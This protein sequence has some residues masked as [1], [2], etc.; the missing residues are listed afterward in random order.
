MRALSPTPP[1]REL[2][3]EHALL[4][5]TWLGALALLVA[6]DHWLKGSGLL[7][8]VLT[9]KLSDFAGMLVAPVLLASLL[10]VGTRRGLLAC[11]VAVVVV[12][13]A[14]QLSPEF[15]R[16]WSGLM[17]L[18]GHPWVITCDPTDLIAVPFAWLSW[19]L[20][21]PEMA[22]ERPALVGL[23]RTAV[24]TVS[25]FGLWATVATSDDSGSY[26]ECWNCWDDT[27]TDG[28]ETEETWQDVFGHVY[29]HN[30]NSFDIGITIRTLAF[31]VAIDC[32][33]IAEDPARL[34]PDH[35]FG[36]AE[37]WLLPPTT[38]VAI[39]L[40]PTC[41]AAKVGGEGIQE[42]I[43]FLPPDIE[44]G[45]EM[46]PGSHEFIGALGHWGA[47]I[48]M[49]SDGSEWVGGE[50]WRYT[51]KTDSDPLPEQCTPDPNER[52][53]DW[54]PLPNSYTVQVLSMT[55]GLDGCFEFELS[56]WTSNG[57]GPSV[58]WYLCAP[59]PSVR[60]EP[61]SHYQLVS[62]TQPIPAI[63]ARLLD[64]VTLE[65]AQNELGHPLFTARWI[66][67]AYDAAAIPLVNAVALPAGE[68]PWSVSE[69]CPIVERNLDLSL[70]G[71]ALDVAPG[72]PAVHL[73]ATHRHEFTLGRARSIGLIDTNCTGN[74][75]AMPHLIDYALVS[76]ALIP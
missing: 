15:A 56:P 37:H 62:T 54:S 16:L 42:Q 65:P 20:L 39:D 5:P 27:G 75:V 41:G 51:P 12:F 22:P 76:E 26:E 21:I 25:V 69:D 3:P 10:R 32:H 6:N 30:P 46:F 4:T 73:D 52:R 63:E 50:A 48:V 29:I 36:P 43:V 24:A 72:V 47:A 14:I 74:G 28:G 18:F 17:G 7:P 9:G 33:A 38:N 58:T 13:A 23:R 44:H 57:Y 11:H 35:A 8:D 60:L 55:A 66:R 34:L 19:R 53:I 59:E 2:R 61:L 71:G 45:V 68:C 40:G 67:G 49:D 64:P 1:A 70:A 31:G